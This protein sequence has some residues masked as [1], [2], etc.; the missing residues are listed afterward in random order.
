[1]HKGNRILALIL[2]ASL[3]GLS[4]CAYRPPVQQ[5]TII[6]NADIQL[7]RRGM[8]RTEVLQRLGKPVLIN[9]YHDNRLVYVYT[10]KP[11][12]EARQERQLLIY[13]RSGRV[14]NYKVYSSP[15]LKTPV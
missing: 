9:L 8:T 14:A 4:G 7:V 12:R 2:T 11:N 10:L 13:F 1:M 6:S 5:G 3:L 15:N